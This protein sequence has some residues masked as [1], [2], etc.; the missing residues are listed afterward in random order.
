MLTPHLP[1]LT[2]TAYPSFNDT[3]FS[4]ILGTN[5]GNDGNDGYFRDFKSKGIIQIDRWHK[6]AKLRPYRAYPLWIYTTLWE[7]SDIPVIAVTGVTIQRVPHDTSTSWCTIQ[8]N[9]RRCRPL[10][11]SGL[12]ANQDR[13]VVKLQCLFCNHWVQCSDLEIRVMEDVKAAPCTQCGETGEALR[14]K[15][16]EV[17]RALERWLAG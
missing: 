8:Q 14:A 11:I 6:L 5:D 15:A 3:S 12:E 13:V 10:E 7:V 17:K 4:P 16:E 1:C 9:D 2:M